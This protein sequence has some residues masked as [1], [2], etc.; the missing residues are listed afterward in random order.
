MLLDERGWFGRAPIEIHAADASPLV[1]ERAVKGRF[2]ERSF[3]A[4]PEPLRDRYFTRGGELWQ[5]DPVL[6]ARIRSWSVLNLMD[7]GELARIAGAPIVFCRN[8]LI[9]FD[10]AGVRRVV[11]RLARLMP[12][13][14]YLCVGASESPLKLNTVF[15]LEEIG[16]A[17]VYVKRN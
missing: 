15:Q 14:G 6:H 13:P 8:V 12:S 17:F 10:Q 1:I 9:Y 4:L 11:E 5:V 3:R 7:D 2:R 16:G